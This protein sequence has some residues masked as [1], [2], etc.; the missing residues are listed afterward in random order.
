VERCF[1]KDE[2][3]TNISVYWFTGTI[4]SSVRLYY[5]TRKGGR[6]GF[7]QGRVELPTGCAIFPKELYKS[8]RR[9]AEAHY[10]VT[11]WT[12][13]PRGGHFAA[14]EQPQLLAEDLRAFFSTLR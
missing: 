11:H 1:S 10:N 8:P 2:L 9:W 14:W 3:L 4:N 7:T 12:E 5:E 13:M 6:A